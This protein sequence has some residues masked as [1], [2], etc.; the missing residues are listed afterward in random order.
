MKKTANH[1]SFF[2]ITSREFNL[3]D[4]P[5]EITL[6]IELVKGILGKPPVYAGCRLSSESTTRTIVIRQELISSQLPHLTLAGSRA[7]LAL[8]QLWLAANDYE[9]AITCAKAGL[10][11]LGDDDYASPKVYDDTK[12]K[13]WLAQE[14]IQEGHLADGADMMLRILHTRLNLYAQQHQNGLLNGQPNSN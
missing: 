3:T 5:A 11:E 8:A 7:W 1:K 10:E 4:A 2:E 6:P 12:M 14:R 13:L 9:G